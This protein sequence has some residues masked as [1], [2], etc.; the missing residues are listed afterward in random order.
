[1]SLKTRA[2][3][4]IK[5][6]PEVV[7]FEGGGLTSTLASKRP[8]DSK[9][10]Y[11][12]FMSAKVSKINAQAPAPKSEKERKEDEVDRE[13]D[14]QL[15]ELLEGRTMIEKLHESQLSGKER[16]KHNT[17]K[18]VKLGMKIKHKEKMPI[19]M[20]FNSE[21]ARAGRAAKAIKDVRDRGLLS[22]S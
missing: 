2:A 20:Y 18:L 11:K 5:R 16:H 9:F 1:M 21:R 3:P 19:D 12:S 6:E 10:A 13:H 7:V 14:R 22:A 8:S 17:Q 15:A 4:R